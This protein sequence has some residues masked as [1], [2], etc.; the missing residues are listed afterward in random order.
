MTA[1]LVWSTDETDYSHTAHVGGTAWRDGITAA[2][3]AGDGD[4]DL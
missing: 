1:A 3:H 2:Q 4:D